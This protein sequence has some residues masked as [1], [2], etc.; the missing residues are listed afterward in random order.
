MDP[1]TPHDQAFERLPTLVERSLLQMQ[2]NWAAF[3][4]RNTA[5]TTS[6]S[7]PKSLSRCSSSA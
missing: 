6:G 7:M 3:R 5:L 2:Q 1:T 4:H